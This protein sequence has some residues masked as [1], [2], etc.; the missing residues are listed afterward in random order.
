MI[1]NAI[2]R[3]KKVNDLSDDTCRLLFTWLITSTDCEGR[4]YGD[5][6]LVKSIVFPRRLDITIDMVEEYLQEMQ[7]SGLIMR[8]EVDGDQY[9]WFPNFDKNQIGLRKDREP[10]SELPA[11]PDEVLRKI[12]GR[13]PDDCR[14]IDGL[15]E[16][17]EKRSRREVEVEVEPE[18]IS[19]AA[20]FQTYEKEIGV[21]T[22]SVGDKIRLYLED[23]KIPNQWIIDAME[24]ASANNARNWKYVSAI[25]DRWSVEGKGDR[26]KRN[27]GGKSAKSTGGLSPELAALIGADDGN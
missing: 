16:V 12:A 19:T 4:T 26:R 6:A 5:A 24:E 20:I 3:D 11:A 9:I 1:N 25:L 22:K 23:E 2:C 8:Y 27:S 21:I 10:S 7:S 17:E 13:L 18:I 14:M 15:R